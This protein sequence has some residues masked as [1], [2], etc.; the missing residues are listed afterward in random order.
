MIR[1]ILYT[2]E[3]ALFGVLVLLFLFF[4]WRVE[5]FLDP[6]G[7]LDRTPYWAIT[8]LIALPMTFIIATSGIDLSVGSIVALC[9][10]ILGVLHQDLGIPIWF[11]ALAAVLAGGIAGAL[12]GGVSSY[13]GVP[14][15]VVTLA[16]MVL[17]RGIAMALSTARGLSNF[18][19]SFVD[20]LKGEA[21]PIPIGN[22]MEAALPIPLIVLLIA[23]FLA[24][25]VMRK[26]RI[27]RFTEHIGEN[28]TAAAFAAIGVRRL[29][30]GL[31][32]AC[33][34]ICG[35]AA[36]FFVAQFKTAKANV[37]GGL[38]LQAIACVVIGGTRI[39]GG[40]ASILGT[41]FGLFIIGILSYGLELADVPEYYAIIVVGGLLFVTAVFNEWMARRQEGERE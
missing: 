20:L 23:A 38:E 19:Q 39:S 4:A 28:E 17:F 8:G 41:L 13:L 22:G 37:A 26:T 36:L 6:L 27:G 34:L 35:L 33:G 2:R 18:P 9:G 30:L 5:Y 1:R 16:T 10:V 31:Y 7:L 14:P 15:L 40:R 11:A 32:I 24:W 25:L 12:N 21:F 3:T 29:K